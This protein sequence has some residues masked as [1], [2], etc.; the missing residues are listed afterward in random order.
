MNFTKQFR[1]STDIRVTSSSS[2]KARKWVIYFG[3][4]EEG[5]EGRAAGETCQYYRAKQ[6]LTEPS[7]MQTRILLS[8]LK[9][10]MVVLSST[11]SAR[12]RRQK[13]DHSLDG[14]MLDVLDAVMQLWPKLAVS[15][16]RA[17]QSAISRDGAVTVIKG[18]VPKLL[19]S[20]SL[21]SYV[22]PSY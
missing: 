21:W 9:W 8:G 22:R 20:I 6:C 15:D 13:Y 18:T 16:W 3:R 1:F 10:A 12:W 17:A 5:R 19:R 4:R 11:K 2:S 7:T 14:R